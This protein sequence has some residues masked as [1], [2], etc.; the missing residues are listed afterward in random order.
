ML[1][2]GLLVIYLLTLGRIAAVLGIG[3]EWGNDVVLNV[4]LSAGGWIL[5]FLGTFLVLVFADRVLH[6]QVFSTPSPECPVCGGKSRVNEITCYSCGRV[7]KVSAVP[8]HLDDAVKV[9]GVLGVVVLLADPVAKWWG[10]AGFLGRYGLS[11]TVAF[12]V[13]LPA[14]VVAYMVESREERSEDAE[15]F[16]KLSFGT[17]ELIEAVG[18]TGRAGTPTLNK[19]TEVYESRTGE[20]IAYQEILRKLDRAERTGII[21]PQVDNVQDEPKQVW[22]SH[23]RLADAKQTQP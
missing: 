12:C 5:I 15:F 7:L 21:E 1:P 18:Q 13:F 11:L 10:A 22:R 20:A 16:K 8:F 9:L 4:F 17:R 6:M 3:Y 2:I 14:L 23:L 19:I